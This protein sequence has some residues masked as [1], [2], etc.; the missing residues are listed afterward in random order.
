MLII[1][2]EKLMHFPFDFIFAELWHL[3]DVSAMVGYGAVLAAL[4]FKMSQN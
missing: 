1:F 3:L 2:R 4:L